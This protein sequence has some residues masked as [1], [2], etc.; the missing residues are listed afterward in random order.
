[1]TTTCR[2]C[3]RAVALVPEDKAFRAMNFER[4][5]FTPSADRHVCG[6]SDRAVY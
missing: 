6:E 3:Q 4:D 5:G 2:N 1:M